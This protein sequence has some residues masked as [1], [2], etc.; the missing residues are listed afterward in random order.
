MWCLGF[1]YN[2]YKSLESDI[3]SWGL[4][5]FLRYRIITPFVLICVDIII[6]RLLRVYPFLFEQTF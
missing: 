5:L 2:D 1:L 6:Y 4:L 3:W